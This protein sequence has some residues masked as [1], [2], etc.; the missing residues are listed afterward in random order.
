MS[1][2]GS[3][4][5]KLNDANEK[6]KTHISGQLHNI[7]KRHWLSYRFWQWIISFFGLKRLITTLLLLFQWTPFNSIF[8]WNKFACFMLRRFG[9]HDLN[10]TTL[11]IFMYSFILTRLLTLLVADSCKSS[12]D[13]FIY[14]LSWFIRM[15]CYRPLS[16]SLDSFPAK[17]ER[18]Y[19]E[20]YVYLFHDF[21]IALLI[22][23]SQLVFMLSRF[24]IM[25]HAF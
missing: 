18:I 3:L 16:S 23:Q 9:S 2:I 17:L 21:S 25:V 20:P 14:F 7:V 4:L 19:D 11:V 12:T 15:F 22:I 5:G 24:E 10:L 8:W 1:S 6:E 13:V